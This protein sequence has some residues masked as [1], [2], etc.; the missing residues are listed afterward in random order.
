MDRREIHSHFTIKDIKAVMKC[1]PGS[2]KWGWTVMNTPA[3]KGRTFVRETSRKIGDAARKAGIPISVHAPY[4]INLANV[5]PEKRKKSRQYI[6]DTLEVAHYMGGKRVVF[7][8]GSLGKQQRAEALTLALAEMRILF[9][10]VDAGPFGNI[11]LCPETM[12]K[13]NQLGDLG[14]I[15][16]LCGVDER[17][18]PTIDFGHP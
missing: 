1:R 15:L 12:G 3:V 5:D 11:T 2:R 6:H 14:E 18:I 7:H 16:V 10:E 4:Y 9:E 13:I 8:P 17:L